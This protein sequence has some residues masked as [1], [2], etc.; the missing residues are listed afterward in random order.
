M[1]IVVE[2]LAAVC[3]IRTAMY[4]AKAA[5]DDAAMPANP[6]RAAGRGLP[7]DH[8]AIVAGA[9]LVD[10]DVRKAPARNVSWRIKPAGVG[11][12]SS[13]RGPAGEDRD[14]ENGRFSF[15]G[16]Q[17]EGTVEARRPPRC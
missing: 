4:V 7:N 14:L 12:E 9:M 17:D 16:S 10:R 6:H 3:E 5:Q 11:I 15:D 1:G 2:R 13:R 8:R